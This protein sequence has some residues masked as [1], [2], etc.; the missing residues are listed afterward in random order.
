MTPAPRISEAWWRLA[1]FVAYALVSALRSDLRA[2]HFLFVGL[3]VALAWGGR[4]S[5]ELLRGLYPFALV[6]LLFDAMRPLR[7]LGL[8]TARVHVCDVRGVEARLF[9]LDGG[10]AERITLHDWFRAHDS[11]ALDVACAIPYATFLFVCVSAAVWLYVVDRLALPRFAW[12]FFALNVAGFA[13]YHLVPTA[14]PWYFHA[15]GC[16]VDLTTHAT[17]GPALA[18]V[19]ALL[20]VGYFHAMYG[21]ASSV[22]GAIPSLHCAYPLLVAIEGWRSFGRKLRVVAIAYWL[23]MLFSAIY[24]DHHWVIDA[25]VGC[26]YAIIVAGAFRYASGLA[27]AEAPVTFVAAEGAE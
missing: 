14:P 5:K 6:A 2:E 4:R 8:T 1:P 16:A 23:A 24:L 27:H 25:L 20:G 11:L 10:A 22:F 15:H 7:N 21:K 18:R 17:E 13:T 3:I 12:G 19:D 9:G 26:A